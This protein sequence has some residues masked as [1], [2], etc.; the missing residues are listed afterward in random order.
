MALLLLLVVSWSNPRLKEKRLFFYLFRAFGNLHKK[1]YTTT[2]EAPAKS[3]YA[4][5][6]RYLTQKA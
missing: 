6:D 4:S 2:V 5:G 3:K 1:F